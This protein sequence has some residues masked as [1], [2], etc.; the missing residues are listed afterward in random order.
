M[1]LAKNDDM[2]HAVPTYGADEPFA[3]RIL[4]RAPRCRF[5]FLDADRLNPLYHTSP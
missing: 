3:E 4:A 2:V 1:R 5:D